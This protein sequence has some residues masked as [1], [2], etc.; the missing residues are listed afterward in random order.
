[1]E[2][3]TRY[4]AESKE[5]CP[6]KIEM[7]SNDEITEKLNQKDDTYYDESE[8]ECNTFLVQYLKENKEHFMKEVKSRWHQLSKQQSRTL[9]RRCKVRI[10]VGRI[11]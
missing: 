1:M 7:Y 4:L 6:E 5:I 9:F 8:R 2:N 3:S 11:K 10:F